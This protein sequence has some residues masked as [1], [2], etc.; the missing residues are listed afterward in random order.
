MVVTVPAGVLPGQQLLAAG[1]RI[2]VPPGAV[3][4]TRLR[5]QAPQLA[6]S[7]V[8]S[9][10]IAQSSGLVDLKTAAAAA[11]GSTSSGSSSASTLWWPEQREAVWEAPLP[12]PVWDGVSPM[13]P[14]PPAVAGPFGFGMLPPPIAGPMPWPVPGGMV[15]PPIMPGGP[16]PMAAVPLP[17]PHGCD[18]GGHGHGHDH[19]DAKEKTEPLPKGWEQAKDPYGRTYYFII[20]KDHDGSTHTQW[21]RPDKPAA[22]ASARDLPKPTQPTLGKIYTLHRKLL[23]KADG[24]AMEWSQD[25]K[26]GVKLTEHGILPAAN[27]KLTTSGAVRAEYYPK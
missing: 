9:T 7:Q 22:D 10:A 16:F 11:V 20:M 25:G 15:M 21:K 23:I 14:P 26:G 6:S 24:R 4:G 5:F 18:C 13:W 1:H 17:A 3:A 12:L 8:S 2:T 19:D 27:R